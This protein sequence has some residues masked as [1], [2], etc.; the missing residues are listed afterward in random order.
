MAVV[1]ALAARRTGS[2]DAGIAAGVSGPLL[3]WS[4]YAAVGPRH[5]DHTSQS[6]PY[7]SALPGRLMALAVAAVTARVFARRR[8]LVRAG[9]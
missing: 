9:G 3:I 7:Y 1:A 6:T 4:V 8:A 2:R 5:Y